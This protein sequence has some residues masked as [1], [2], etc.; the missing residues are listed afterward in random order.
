MK[1]TNKILG[2]MLLS[3][4]IFTSCADMDPLEY[5]FEK[6]ANMEGMEYLADYEALKDYK[7]ENS[8]VSPDFKL[9]IALAATEYNNNGMWTRLANANFDEVVAGNEMKM[10]SIVNEKGAMDFGTY[11]K[12]F[13]N[14]CGELWYECLW[15]YAR[16]ALTAASKMVEYHS[17]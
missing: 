11:C 16:M 13:R 4:A 15:S 14:Q 7:S 6:P 9:G 1:H 3:V 8:S 5:A 10:A 17:G 2:T 12:C